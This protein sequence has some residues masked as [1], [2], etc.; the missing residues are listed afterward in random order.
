[1]LLELLWKDRQALSGAACFVHHNHIAP[2]G[3]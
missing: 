3:A 1:M 2:D